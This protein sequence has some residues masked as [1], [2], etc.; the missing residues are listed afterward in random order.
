[1]VYP[2]HK[3]PL[4]GIHSLHR[5]ASVIQTRVGRLRNLDDLMK[6]FHE[7]VV[8]RKG[9][10]RKT[11]TPIR[12]M[13]RLHNRMTLLLSRIEMPDYLHSGRKGRSYQTNAKAHDGALQNFQ[14]DISKFYQSTSWH[15]V[16]LCFH[17]NF[18]CGSDIAGIIASLLTYEGRIPT[19]SPVSSLLS[20]FTHKG[21]F[22]ELEKISKENGLRITVFQDDISF[23][24][25]KID[26]SFRKQVRQ[27]IKRQDLIPKR[28]KQRFYHGGMSPKITGIMLTEKG[29]RAPWSR[30]LALKYALDNFRNA[31]SKGELKK[32][33]SRLMGRVSEIHSIEG[34]FFALK[35]SLKAEYK[36]TINNMV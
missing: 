3:S 22:D 33:Y 14:V 23:S 1:M 19:G 16:Y 12:T 25:E 2:V 29:A 6:Q 10:Q 30:H 24:G 4:F 20:F 18:R 13:R 8:S 5:L 31:N 26:E 32:S 17:H 9:K 27:I 21:M 15:Q 36:E 28:S 11:E 7:G 35:K 34:R